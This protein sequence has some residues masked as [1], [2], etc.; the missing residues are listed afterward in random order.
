MAL[1]YKFMII[2]III[3]FAFPFKVKAEEIGF[4]VYEE[5]V[6]GELI[7]I[8]INIKLEDDFSR[9]KKLEILIENL[10]N[11]NGNMIKY[12]NSETKIRWI[13]V[14]DKTAI[15]SFSEDIKKYG[16]NFYE[17]ALIYELART[18][19]EI[20]DIDYFTLYINDRLESLNEGHL[21][22]NFSR[23]DLKYYENGFTFK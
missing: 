8:F 9:V 16:G 19:F 12:I 22:Y 7:P 1:K 21:I 18:I 10:L 13:T 20:S 17:N 14:K 5:G 4:F 23:E 15:I 11:Y 2:F 3:I 6:N